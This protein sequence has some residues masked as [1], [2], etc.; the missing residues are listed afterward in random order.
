[1]P[2]PTAL[3]GAAVL[4]LGLSACSQ[5]PIDPALDGDRPPR[6]P[7]EPAVEF[8]HAFGSIRAVMALPD[9]R[10]VVSDPQE[11][12]VALIDFPKGASQPLG[13]LGEGPREFRRPGGLY[14][15]PGGGILI[16]DQ[17]L[18]RLLPVTP[19]GGLE[20]VV[21]LPAGGLAGDWSTHGPDPLAFDS[22]GQTYESV[23]K[24]WL[25]AP[26]ALVLRYRP[27]SR[28]DTVAELLAG[29]TKTLRA[30]SNGTG[31]Y[32]N[33]LFSPADA[34]AVTPDGWIALVRAA[35]YHVEWA[36][37]SGPV[38]VGP[39]IYQA[40]IR[41]PQAEKELIASGAGGDRGRIEVSLVL[42]KP[43]SAP[44]SHADRP[45][46]IPVGDL[47]FAKVKTPVNLRDGRWP[48]LD[49]R[50]R[51]WVERSRA[52]G[53]TGS[54]FDVFDRTGAL[55]DRVALPAG[56]RLV[57]FDDTW[58]YAA[59]RDVDDLEYLQRYALGR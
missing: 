56:T 55:V 52:G 58:L 50:G 17:G 40:P 21:R 49:E 27:G 39:G 8:G 26:T 25:Q 36:P 28:P 14:R 20:N 5:P 6:R 53:A 33:V 51:I 57:G 3:R 1:M 30:N 41:I 46:P 47:L 2:A 32:Q 54:V 22:L 23:R 19:T 11:N 9:G 45:S 48:L 31:T 15:G 4:W 13:R 44:P 35:P 24:G 12:R 37:P 18:M 38:I 43:G 29:Q 59:R 34:W 7:P 16:F 42:I 10:L